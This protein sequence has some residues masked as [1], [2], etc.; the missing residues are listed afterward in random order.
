M[1]TVIAHLIFLI[2]TVLLVSNI[3][4]GKDRPYDGKNNQSTSPP[5]IGLKSNMIAAD[6]KNLKDC[7]E[8]IKQATGSTLK[9]VTN[10]PS[11]ISGFLSNGEHFGCVEKVTDEKGTYI[12]G[13]YTV[14]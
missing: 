7:M 4:G 5:V 8:D 9:I 13:W 3:H 14:K 2:S 12:D 1:K 10:Q 11:Q 6:Y